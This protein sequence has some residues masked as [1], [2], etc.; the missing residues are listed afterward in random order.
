MSVDS[1]DAAQRA[2]RARRRQA[3]QIVAEYHEQQLDALLEHVREGLARLDGGEIDV[4]E[5]NEL[6]E[7]YQRAARKL[8]AFCGSSGAD[9]ERAVGML[10]SCARTAKRTTGGTPPRAASADSH[11]VRDPSALPRV[12]EI[13]AR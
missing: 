7:G 5:V 9:W 13:N 1:E 2:Q 12:R 6:I 3:R 8:W 11:R 10:R 4:F